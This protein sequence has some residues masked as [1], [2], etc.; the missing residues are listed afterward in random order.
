VSPSRTA[1]LQHAQA[2]IGEVQQRQRSPLPE[3]VRGGRR[4]FDAYQCPSEGNALNAPLAGQGVRL[5]MAQEAN[6]NQPEQHPG[7]SEIAKQRYG[8]HGPPDEAIMCHSNA[9]DTAAGRCLQRLPDHDDP[10]LHAC[11]CICY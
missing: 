7:N 5:P 10:S 2:F 8:G 9:E 6:G 1:A 3:M 4:E 11:S